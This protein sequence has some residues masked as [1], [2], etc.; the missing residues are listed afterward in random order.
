LLTVYHKLMLAWELDIKELWYY[1]DSKT[2]IKL[3]DEPI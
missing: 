2:I 1:S 3:L